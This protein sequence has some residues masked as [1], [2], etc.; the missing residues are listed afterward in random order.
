M[1]SKSDVIYG[2]GGFF[3]CGSLYK[4]TSHCMLTAFDKD[5]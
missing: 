5:R 1:S 2:E 4:S 3:I